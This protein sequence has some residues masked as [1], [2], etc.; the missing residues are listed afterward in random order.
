MTVTSVQDILKS[1]SPRGDLGFSGSIG[2]TGSA[3]GFVGSR[4]E[5]SYTYAENPPSSPAVGD[6][7]FDSSDGVEY[8]WT[9]DG[10][11]TTWVEIAASGFLGPLGYAGSQGI[12]GEY[13]GMGYT[14]SSAAGYVGS[15]G[16]GYAGSS[17]A[18]AALGYTGSFGVGYTGSTS[19]YIGSFGYTGSAGT[20]GI[21]GYL[22]S[23]GDIGYTGSTS[24]YIGSFGYTGSIGTGIANVASTA[25]SSPVTG[26]MWFD[27]TANVNQLKIWTTDWN[28]AT[29]YFTYT[30]SLTVA[31]ALTAQQTSEVINTTTSVTGTVTHDFNLGTVFYHKNPAA[32]FVVN[33][34]NVPTTNNRSI[35]LAVV[36]EQTGTAYIPTA[37]QIDGSA[38]TLKWAAATTATGHSTSTDIISYSLLRQFGSWSVMANSSYYS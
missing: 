20:N 21:D 38:Q 18:F 5:S 16:V 14:G 34:T 1:G 11:T 22:G 26:Q 13:A 8:V 7:W 32:N 36:I 9:D 17:G 6:R 10:T 24:G 2:Y 19:G 3:A 31:G 29:G 37:M 12:P 28:T 4:G 25:P 35:V 33:F 23:Q 30:N 15:Q 27:T